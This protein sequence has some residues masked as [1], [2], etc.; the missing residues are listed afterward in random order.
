MNRHPDVC[1]ANGHRM[2]LFFPHFNVHRVPFCIG[3]HFCGIFPFVLCLTI[4]KKPRAS[5]WLNGE[6]HQ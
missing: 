6:Q 4:Q 2:G 3:V 5:G 1:D